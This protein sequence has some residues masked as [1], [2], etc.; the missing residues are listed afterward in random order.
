[1]SSAICSVLTPDVELGPLLEELE[2]LLGEER[3]R[4]PRRSW[5]VSLGEEPV[6][7]E[8]TLEEPLDCRAWVMVETNWSV[9]TPLAW[10]I[11]WKLWPA[12]RSD[13]NWLVLTP[14]TCATALI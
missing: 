2:L 10:A 9:D 3:P 11:D 7:S 6:M 14:R 1:M 13:C 5:L 8:L 12:E 4:R